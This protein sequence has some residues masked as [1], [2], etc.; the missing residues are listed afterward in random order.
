[1]SLT[2][3]SAI[4]LPPSIEQVLAQR[5]FDTPEKIDALLNPSLNHLE[6]PHAFA[7]MA[8][9]VRRLL[10]AVQAEQPIAIYA[11]RDVDGLSGL[12]VLVRSLR[13]L[14]G[15]V[16][17]GSPV[18]GRGL[19]RAVLERLIQ[20]GAK[21][22]VLVDCG[23]GEHAELAWL[24][25]QGIDVIVADHHRFTDIRPEA[26]AWI[27]PGTLKNGGDP[28]GC[29]MAFKLAHAIWISFLGESD[30]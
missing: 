16:V 6:S 26:F 3:E 15:R 19:E 23:T 25:S 13:S 1:M 27:H 21:V 9:A 7:D 30:P 18:K 10:D 14:G 5:G 2:L 4:A 29:V 20:S 11:D 8:I 24:K 28:A 12:A 17:W 22:M